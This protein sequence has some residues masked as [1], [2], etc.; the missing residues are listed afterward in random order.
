MTEIN[1]TRGGENTKQKHARNTTGLYVIILLSLPTVQ[2]ENIVSQAV[3]II[4]W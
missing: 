3:K 4:L 1:T 2:G